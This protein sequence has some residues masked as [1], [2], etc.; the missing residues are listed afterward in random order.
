MSGNRK[1]RERAEWAREALDV[2]EARTAPLGG[3]DM[4]TMVGDLVVDLLHLLRFEGVVK[5]KDARGWLE[6][7]LSI[8]DGEVAD[9]E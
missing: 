7:R 5:P 3:E 6:G 8:Y 4:E 2:F 1:N 9:R